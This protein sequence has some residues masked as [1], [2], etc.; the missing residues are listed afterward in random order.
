MSQ[1]HLINNDQTERSF[2][3]QGGELLVGREDYCDIRLD[4]PGISRKHLR[5]LTVM[6]DT[7]LEDL[8]SKNGTYVNGRLARKCA[9]NDGDIIQLGEI[10]LRFEKQAEEPAMELP[11]DPDATTVIQPGQ[12]GP[13]SR[14]AR[15]AGAAV[16]GISPV[17]DRVGRTQQAAR[18]QPAP[19]A[20][21]P[22]RPGFWKRMF[23]WLGG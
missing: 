6:D 9:L 21:E 13:K 2:S 7:F 5:L 19:A 11:D 20:A 4:Y 15:E 8:A 18:E 1:L 22:A 16:A 12:F 14:A 3:L 17:A 23:G 10:E